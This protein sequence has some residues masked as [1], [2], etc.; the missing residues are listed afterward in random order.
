MD[1]IPNICLKIFYL[2][3]TILL[4]SCQTLTFTQIN[5][6]I[7]DMP[8]C[9]PQLSG[10]SQ[11]VQIPGYSHAW[12]IVPDCAYFSI[13]SVSIVMS[14]FYLRWVTEFTDPDRRLLKILND[15]MIQWGHEK[16]MMPGYTVN[17]DRVESSRVLGLVITPGVIWIN[18]NE[19]NKICKTSFIH[20]LVHLGLISQGFKGDPDHEGTRYLGWTPAHTRFIN[21]LNTL[22]CGMGF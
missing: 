2:T 18:I 5:S 15:L 9:N 10:T 1:I 17:G 8:R 6:H 7:N 19:K 13:E 16:K 21:D 11:L 3:I 14:Y 22:M 12:H 4:L 20:E